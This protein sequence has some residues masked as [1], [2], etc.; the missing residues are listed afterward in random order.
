M[1]IQGKTEDL[2]AGK[3]KAHMAHSVWKMC[4]F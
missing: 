2:G 1:F 3:E 4:S